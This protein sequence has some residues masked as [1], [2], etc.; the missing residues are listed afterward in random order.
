LE[1]DT[2]SHC[3]GNG[4]GLFAYSFNVTDIASTWDETRAVLGKGGR[5]IVQAFSEMCEGLPFKVRDIDSDYGSE[6]LNRE[7]YGHCETREIGFTRSRPYKK[8]DN[9]H[10]EQKN[11]THV[12]KL[13]GWDRYATPEAVAALNRG[14]WFHGRRW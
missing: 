13:V 8:D 14:T 11:W 1:L 7:L 6:F 12:R 9:P 2:V 4:E 10:I 5:G 3:G